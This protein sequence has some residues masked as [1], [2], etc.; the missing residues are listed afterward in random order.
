MW[1]TI[2][3]LATAAGTLVLAVATFAS[4]RS[5]NRS[6][7]IAEESLLVAL[8]PLLVPSR[9]QDEPQEIM[10]GDGKWVSVPGGSGYAE[11]QNGVI[12]LA[13]SIRNVGPGIGVVHGWYFYPDRDPGR[14]PTPVENFRL[15]VRDLYLPPG[16]E[17]FW[18]GAFRDPSD[19]QHQRACETVASR[20]PLSVDLLY[21]DYEGGQRVITRF[22]LSPGEDGG[23]LLS[24]ARH[25]NVDRPDPRDRRP[26]YASL[27][28]PAAVEGAVAPAAGQQVTGQGA[29]AAVGSTGNSPRE[30]QAT[31]RR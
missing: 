9:L 16:E 20:S 14:Q 5:A 12:Y 23:W 25:W 13:A 8:R 11:T 28:A 19:P 3:N 29:R 24:A 31:D 17:G 2:A 27:V 4:I 15:Q 18:Q 30:A 1:G 21:G 26:D 22:S 7:R 10:F 6:A